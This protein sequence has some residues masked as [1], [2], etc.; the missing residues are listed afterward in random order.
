[1]PLVVPSL[2]L[3]RHSQLRAFGF[4]NPVDPLV[5]VPNY[6]VESTSQGS[7]GYRVL[8]VTNQITVFYGTVLFND[9][10]PC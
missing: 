8:A 5:S 1:M 9:A 10:A 3:G 2:A 7:T 4:L 6:Y